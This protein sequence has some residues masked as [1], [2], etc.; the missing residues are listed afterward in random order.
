[1][2]CG[3][4]YWE[5]W[6][7]GKGQLAG[8]CLPLQFIHQLQ[9]TQGKTGFFKTHFFFFF[10]KHVATISQKQFQANHL[11]PKVITLTVPA[12]SYGASP[13]VRQREIRAPTLRLTELSGKHGGGSEATQ[14]HPP[15]GPPKSN[16]H[17]PQP[18]RALCRP[19]VLSR[20]PAPISELTSSSRS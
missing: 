4:Y 15:P 3:R 10:P 14:M 8:A 20:R 1:M 7:E 17:P 2:Q 5:P 13:G 6:L 9:N 19:A 12:P 11:L 16:L 18:Q